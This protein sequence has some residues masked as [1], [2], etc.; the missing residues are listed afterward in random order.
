VFLKRKE[1]T[2]WKG[3]GFRTIA[4]TSFLSSHKSWAVAIDS[5]GQPGRNA[6]LGL[7]DRP[8]PIVELLH[9]HVLITGVEQSLPGNMASLFVCPIARGP[10]NRVFRT[11]AARGLA[12][13]S[14]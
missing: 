10:L 14:R 1:Q 4:L 9:F 11:R 7:N 12:E 5:P 13:L 8:N 2:N 6:I 3:W